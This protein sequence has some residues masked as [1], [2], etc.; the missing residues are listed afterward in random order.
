MLRWFFVAALAMLAV[1]VACGGDDNNASTTPTA[2]RT[3]AVAS[4]GSKVAS[5]D[6]TAYFAA[7]KQI[8]SDANA[9]IAALDVTYPQAFKG[10]VQQTKDD[11][12]DYLRIFNDADAKYIAMNVPD[13]L[14]VLHADILQAD[15]ETAVISQRRLDRLG[16]ATT[17]ADVDAIFANAPDFTAVAAHGHSACLALEAAA[18]PYGI[19]FDLPCEK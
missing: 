13:E 18:V 19:A 3:T 12:R 14:K 7:Y 5:G 8:N 9:Q 15:E 11:F 2:A 16:V 10:D 1:A 17:S 6:V 4:A